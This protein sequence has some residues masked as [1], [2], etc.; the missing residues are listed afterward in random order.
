MNKQQ[1]DEE[2]PPCLHQNLRLECSVKES[3]RG[4]SASILSKLAD[5]ETAGVGGDWSWVRLARSSVY[6]C[7]DGGYGFEA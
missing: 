3:L 4:N 2:D 1:K 6:F 7:R 5:L